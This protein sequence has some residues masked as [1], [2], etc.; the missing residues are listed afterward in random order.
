MFALFFGGRQ[1]LGMSRC[2][3]TCGPLGCGG[4]FHLEQ[5]GWLCA[6]DSPAPGIVSQ[7]E[8]TTTDAM[9]AVKLSVRGRGRGRAGAGG[10]AAALSAASA[11]QMLHR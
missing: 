2:L 6:R 4:S 7:F 11:A 5:D 3:S 1:F 9:T 8:W 10:L